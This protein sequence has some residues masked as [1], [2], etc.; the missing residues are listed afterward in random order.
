LDASVAA[1]SVAVS[2]SSA[3]PVSTILGRVEEVVGS[4]AAGGKG[5]VITGSLDGS[6]EVGEGDVSDVLGYV[7]YEADS[8]AYVSVDFGP[9][10][11][12]WR[13]PFRK[14]TR[15]PVEL[16]ESSVAAKEL[17]RKS[18]VELMALTATPYVAAKGSELLDQLDS[19]S[20]LV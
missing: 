13:A 11:F 9:F 17:Y 12:V 2:W 6:I 18:V 7:R 8:V 19:S 3:A 14:T 4:P 1:K 10:E 16:A 20:A 15:S 5:R